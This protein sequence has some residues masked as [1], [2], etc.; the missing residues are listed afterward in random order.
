MIVGYCDDGLVVGD[1]VF[2]FCDDG[3]IVCVFGF[4]DRYVIRFGFDIVG[5]IFYYE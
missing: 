5:L 1:V 4:D 2:D 3:V